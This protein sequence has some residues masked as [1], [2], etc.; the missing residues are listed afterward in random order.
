MPTSNDTRVRV[1]GFSKIIASVLPSSGL[2]GLSCAF[3]FAFM[4]MLAASMLRSSL[5]GSSLRSRKWRS[6]LLIAPPPASTARPTVRR[7]RDRAAAPTPRSR[8]RSRS[9]ARRNR[10]TLSPAPTVSSFWSRSALTRSPDGTTAFTPISSPSPR[11]SAST[12]GIA[13]DH[14][15]Q[16]LL[17]QQRHLLHMIEEAGLEHDIQHRVR[18]G[19]RQRV[20]AEGR[21]VRARRHAGGGFSR[22]EA[23]RRSES[24]RRAPWPATSRRA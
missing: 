8:P 20:A 14:R 9:A 23:R 21:T 10:T 22:G 17:E 18:G 4:A 16:L 11:T 1:D 15:G 5:V 2:A 12:L 13:I 6:A 3:S 24:R 7:R 19:D